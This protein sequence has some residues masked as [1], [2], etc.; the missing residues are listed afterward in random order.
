MEKFTNTLL[1]IISV[2]LIIG[3]I[4]YVSADHSLGDDGIFKDETRVNVTDS[5]GSKWL[6]HVQLVVQNP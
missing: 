5:I 4:Q 3:S 1:G 6:I 2:V